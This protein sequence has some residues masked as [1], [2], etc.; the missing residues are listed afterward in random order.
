MVE[1]FGGCSRFPSPADRHPRDWD[2]SDLIPSEG[3]FDD[4]AADGVENTFIANDVLVVIVLPNGCA[5][6]GAQKVD[7]FGDGGFERAYD[8]RNRTGYGFAR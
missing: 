6:S 3:I 2:S 8:G 5:C 4:V 7:T 1:F